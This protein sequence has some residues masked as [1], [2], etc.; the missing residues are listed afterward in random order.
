MQNRSA[1]C[2]NTARRD[3][4]GGGLTTGR[5]TSILYLYLCPVTLIWK[6]VGSGTTPS[7]DE[8]VSGYFYADPGEFAFGSEF[9]LKV[10]VK[11]YIAKSGWCNIGFNHVTLDNVGI[12]S[13]L[14]YAGIAN[15][16]GT[17]TLSGRLVEHPYTGVTLS[18]AGK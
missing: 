4:R 14:N 6:E 12:S 3:L 16:N 11:I 7:G 2:G 5:P 8:V 17:A 1:R 10:F 13:A 18:A 15:Q 9:N